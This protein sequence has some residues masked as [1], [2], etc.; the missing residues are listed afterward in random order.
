MKM[1]NS[2]YRKTISF[3][4]IA[5]YALV[6]FLI[7]VTLLVFTTSIIKN[8]YINTLKKGM[9]NDCI[10][11]Y[12]YLKA[13]KDVKPIFD[14]K[15]RN[16]IIKLGSHIDLRITIIDKKGTVIADSE[17]ED[18]SRL[19]NHLHREEIL[20]ATE[21]KKG[22]SI[23][24][25]KSIQTHMLYFAQNFSDIFI[26][27]SRPLNEIDLI[28]N[29][30]QKIIIIAG[31][32]IYLFAIAISIIISGRLTTPIRESIT[33]AKKFAN[34]DFSRR[35][36][37]YEENEIGILQKSLNYL[38]DSLEQHIKKLLFE[39]EKL[40]T[41]LESINN[42]IVLVD[43]SGKI[44]LTNQVFLK[45]F[46]ISINPIQRNY[47]EIIRSSNINKKIKKIFNDFKSCHF[48]EILQTGEFCDIYINPIMED[49]KLQGVLVV[50][51]DITEKKKIETV[52]TE[53]VGNLSHELKTPI[54]IVKGY[55][56][57][58]ELQLDNKELCKDFISKAISN[59]D[60]QNS[61]INDM[62]QLNMLETTND[63]PKETIS[64]TE[65]IGSC[66]SILSPKADDKSITIETKLSQGKH[67]LSGNRFLAEQI[68]INLIEN[69]INYNNPDGSINVSTSII[70]NQSITVN[71]R[72][73]GIGIPKE[74]LRRIFERFYR[75]DKGRSR[76]S[77]GT[78]L[79]LSIV[80]HAAEILQW[81]IDV[82]S[83]TT[84]TEFVVTIPSK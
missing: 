23:R 35:I 58:I 78:G 69:A 27:V 43:N 12:N 42:A 3:K 46:N 13:S 74:S 40:E 84:G 75:I 15:T 61:I 65:L 71:I 64:I 11:I 77:G 48:D 2:K 53:L 79:G 8:T 62:L 47:F 16:N 31:I 80:K 54:T 59:I 38:A 34:G 41:T 9:Q 73:T 29:N 36:L 44:I 25:S 82:N 1:N 18:L 68:F 56:E 76:S 63:F 52:K 45:L 24:Y 30:I 19:D 83:S 7:I 6:F 37:N 72:D 21:K 28:L 81:Q 66:I 17:A 22:S 49:N 26:R 39:Q 57:T 5:Y 60:R 33:F 32:T 67:E 55:L 4:V 20:H 70:A 50:L 51:Q 10:L 14:I